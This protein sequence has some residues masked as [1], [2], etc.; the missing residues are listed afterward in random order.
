MTPFWSPKPATSKILTLPP[1]PHPAIAGLLLRPLPM[2]RDPPS[3]LPPVTVTS[4]Q[5]SLSSPLPVFPVPRCSVGN[6]SLPL[7]ARK[8]SRPPGTSP[9]LPTVN[10]PHPSVACKP[11]TPSV[12]EKREGKGKKEKEKKKSLFLQLVW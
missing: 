10:I 1:P 5:S 8:P 12:L 7:E 9:L 3:Q 4:R 2:C 6:P 11:L